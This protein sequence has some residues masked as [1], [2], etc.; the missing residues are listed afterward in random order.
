VIFDSYGY[1]YERKLVEFADGIRAEYIQRSRIIDREL[2]LRRCKACDLKPSEARQS[3]E[4]ILFREDNFTNTLNDVCRYKEYFFAF[5]C[6]EIL[7]A[8][9]REYSKVKNNRFGVAIYGQALRYGKFAVIIARR[10]KS[11]EKTP[12]DQASQIVN[13]VLRQWQDFESRISDLPSN[14]DYFRHY[15]DEER[16]VMVQELNYDNYYKG[17]TLNADL[18][19]FFKT[20]NKT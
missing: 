7:N 5:R 9:A 2:F 16:K 11:N 15:Y 20:A 13:A 8:L 12:L 6:Y 3:G 18:L 4:K 19:N 17:R 14:G 10:L 1:S